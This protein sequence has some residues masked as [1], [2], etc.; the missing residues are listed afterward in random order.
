MIPTDPLSAEFDEFL[1][2]QASEVYVLITHQLYNQ[3][4][5]IRER[6]E[7]ETVTINPF[8]SNTFKVM[9]CCHFGSK[10]IGQKIYIS[11]AGEIVTACYA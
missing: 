8:Q 6:G 10:V 4:P 5:Y 1:L 7:T 9:T 11:L 2:C 3:Q